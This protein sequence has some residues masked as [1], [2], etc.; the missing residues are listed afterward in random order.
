M[1]GSPV[2]EVSHLRKAYGLVVAVEDISFQVS[3]GEIF[4]MVGPNGAGKTTTMP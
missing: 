3:A 2:V 1:N 4:A